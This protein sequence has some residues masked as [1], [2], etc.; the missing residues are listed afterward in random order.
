MR[1]ILS[2]DKIV[3]IKNAENGKTLCI[4][5]GGAATL[6]EVFAWDYSG[7]AN[8]QWYLQP[9][10]AGNQD[11]VKLINVKSFHLAAV[12]GGST[13]DGTRLIIWQDTGGDDQNWIMEKSGNLR[14][15]RAAFTW[16]LQQT[17]RLC[18][19]RPA[20]PG[21]SSGRWRMPMLPREI[22][23]SPPSASRRRRRI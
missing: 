4:N 19:Q 18:R 9:S 10:K 20:I 11:T 1:K 22:R 6:S 2:K 14:M 15:P 8:Q 13:A 16:P 3:S 12:D 5:G 23:Q 21:S 7:E 17:A